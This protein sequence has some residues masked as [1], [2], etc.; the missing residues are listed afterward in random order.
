MLLYLHFLTLQY[1]LLN[2]C[3][4]FHQRTYDA[5]M[6]IFETALTHRDCS[7]LSRQPLA[8]LNITVPL[9]R[10]LGDG[11]AEP[12]TTEDGVVLPDQMVARLT[13]TAGCAGS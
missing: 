5:M 8:T 12:A 7:S 4:M 6:R 2:Q 10:F 13:P 3:L 1:V 11:T 9:K